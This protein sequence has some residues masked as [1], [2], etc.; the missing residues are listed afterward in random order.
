MEGSLGIAAHPHAITKS[1]GILPDVRSER[2][3]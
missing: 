2:N 3:P 1:D